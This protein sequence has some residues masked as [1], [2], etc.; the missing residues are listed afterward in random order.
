MFI[1]CL[2]VA[3]GG[4]ELQASYFG[5]NQRVGSSGGCHFGIDP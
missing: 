5:S 1:D 4:L 2:G 3:W